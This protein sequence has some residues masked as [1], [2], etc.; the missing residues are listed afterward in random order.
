MARSYIALLRKDEGSDYGVEFPDFPGCVT[1]GKTLEE[2]PGWT[3]TVVPPPCPNSR[4]TVVETAA[5]CLAEQTALGGGPRTW[6]N[7]RSRTA[8]G[9]ESRRARPPPK[10][11]SGPNRPLLRLVRGGSNEPQPL[12][13]EVHVSVLNLHRALDV[14]LPPEVRPRAKIEGEAV[15]LGL[16]AG[17]P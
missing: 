13:P 7:R 12:R 11:S 16:A 9:R 5:V 4:H 8:S 2:A 14:Q 17:H 10:N 6:R 1:A 15:A 3:F